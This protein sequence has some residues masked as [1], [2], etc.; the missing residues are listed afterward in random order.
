MLI[1]QQ[2]RTRLYVMYCVICYVTCYIVH[3]LLYGV[4]SYITHYVFS[5]HCYIDFAQTDTSCYIYYFLP[6][7]HGN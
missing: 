3:V 5:R 6:Y 1:L 4:Y 2:L 7:Y